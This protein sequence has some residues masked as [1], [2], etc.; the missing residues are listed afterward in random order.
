MAARLNYFEILRQAALNDELM[1]D[2]PTQM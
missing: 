1:M 2:L